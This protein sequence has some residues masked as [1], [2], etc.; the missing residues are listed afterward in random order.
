MN[1]GDGQ[2]TSRVASV[3]ENSDV[4][5]MDPHLESIKNAI[6]ACE[7]QRPRLTMVRRHENP[8]SI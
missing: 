7:D 8:K 6:D 1:L 4:E 5:A 3:L 2:G